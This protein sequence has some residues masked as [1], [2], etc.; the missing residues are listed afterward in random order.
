MR[1]V[2]GIAA[3]F[4]A[5]PLILAAGQNWLGTSVKTESG[6]RMGNPKAKLQ[7]V[8]YVSY[9]CPH[10]GEFFREA[11]TPIKVGLVQ[12]GTASVEVRHLIRDVVDLTAVVLANCGA[13]SKF[14]GNHEMFFARQDRWLTTWQLTMASQRRRWQSGPL[15]QRLQAVASDL[16][17]YAMMESRGYT[18]SQADQCLADEARITRL[19]D[20]AD[21]AATRDGI[22][23]TP[24][25]T[26]NGKALPDVYNWTS[27]QKVLGAAP[28]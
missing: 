8:E 20:I 15:P 14:W 13:H 4:V 9:T 17:F 11:D 19:A 26:L 12:P 1:K 6:H 27:L 22:D 24:S 3:L 16:D 2:L 5:A 28:K 18:R 7:L 25:F 21:A 23:S 10:C